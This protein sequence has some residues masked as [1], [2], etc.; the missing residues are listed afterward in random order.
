[1]IK[2]LNEAKKVIREIKKEGYVIDFRPAHIVGTVMIRQLSG[3]NIKEPN[4]EFMQENSEVYTCNK[5]D[6]IG[7]DYLFFIRPEKIIE[8]EAFDS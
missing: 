4:I 5:K 1:M 8:S 3:L 7:D 2:D 6:L